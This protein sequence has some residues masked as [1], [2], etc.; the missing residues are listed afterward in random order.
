MTFVFH[1]VVCLCL[2]LIQ[3]TLLPAF[4]LLNSFYDLCIPFVIFLGLMR[5]FRESIL[6]ILL[7]GITVDNLSG[8]PLFLYA[9]VYLWLVISVRM[10]LKFA[11][12]GTHLRLTA[13]IIFGVLFENIFL[14]GFLIIVEPNVATTY[15]QIRTLLLQLFWAALTGPF[16]VIMLENFYKEIVERIGKFIVAHTDQTSNQ[17]IDS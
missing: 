15:S 7:L 8:S 12:V 3:T 6:T 13:L 10:V 14:A 4:S 5:P 11:Q 2:L 16:V 1:F 17:T 9:T